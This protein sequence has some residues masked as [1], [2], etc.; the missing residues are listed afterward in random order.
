MYPG[1]VQDKEEGVARTQTRHPL[2]T[3]RMRFF[4]SNT[5]NTVEDILL[6]V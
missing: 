2:S 5:V 6:T 3:Q 4:A 1:T